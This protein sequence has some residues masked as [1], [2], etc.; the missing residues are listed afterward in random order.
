MTV[1]SER[2]DRAMARASALHRGQVRKSTDVPYISHPMAVASL[3]LEHHG[4]EAQAVAALLHDCLEDTSLTADELRSEFGDDVAEIVVACTD[5]AEGTDPHAK[6]PWRPR[7]EAYLAHLADAP[8]EAL[9]VVAADKLHNA[10]SIA[11]DHARIGDALWERF[12]ARDPADH[13]WYFRSLVASLRGRLPGH[14]LVEQL[15]VTV[16]GIWPTPTTPR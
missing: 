3:V 16:D 7:K 4:T 14:P 9:L 11:S 5:T 15:A 8:A 1:L 6:P 12:N 10:R 2:F 13:E